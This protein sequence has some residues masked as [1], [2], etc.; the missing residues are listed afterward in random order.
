MKCTEQLRN[1]H[2][3][4]D[5]DIDE[6]TNQTLQA[7][8]ASCGECR[9]Y[10]MEMQKVIALVQSA[11]HV[12]APLDFTEKVMAQLPAPSTGIRFSSWLR[13]HPFLTAAA[14][15]LLLMAGSVVTSWVDRDNTLQ[16]SSDSL[17]KLTIDH[18]RNMVVVPSGTVVDGDLI[19][20]NGNIEVFG[21]VKGDVVAIDG[22]VVTAS[23]AQIAGDTE[24]IEAIVDWIWYE[25]KNIGNDLLPLSP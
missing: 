18:Q 24:S 7:H 6:L 23:T 20:E 17:D 13:N 10:L 15:F 21:E 5:G 12:H 8:L 14:V 19:V 4:L 9:R 11:S 22:K 3:Y 1:V 25:L 2:A 16:V